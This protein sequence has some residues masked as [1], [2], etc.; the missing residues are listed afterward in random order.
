[1]RVFIVPSWCPTKERPE[2]GSFFLEQAHAIAQIK[3]DWNV[4]ICTFDLNKS[5]IPWRPGSYFPFFRRFANTP[6]LTTTK[7]ASGLHIYNSFVP[8]FPRFGAESKWNGVVQGLKAHIQIA[9]DAYTLRFGK[10]DLIHAHAV[11]PAG[12]AASMIGTKFNIPVALTEHLG[13]F[14]PPQFRRSDGS[15]FSLI[16]KSYMA[17]SS[18][19]A[20]SSALANEITSAGLAS[21]I[22]VIPNFLPEDYGMCDIRHKDDRSNISILSVGGPSVDKGTDTLLKAFANIDANAKLKIIGSSPEMNYF[23]YVSDSLGISERVQWIGAVSREKMRY[24]YKNCDLFVLPSQSETFGVVLIEALAF[25][26]PLISTYCGGPEDIVNKGN[27]L[28]VPV[29]KVDLLSDAMTRL[30]G[31]LENYDCEQLRNDFL[32]RFSAGTVVDRIES[33]YGRTIA[34]HK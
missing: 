34:N 6:R 23:K 32:I 13:P 12:A 4:A 9:L 28:L 15:I 17:A 24:H 8:Y 5:R 7:A 31:Q 27:G 25:G 1:M 26:K 19:S 11:Y 3:S 2:N 14:P 20:V 22:V 29:G 30:I 16:V 21:D 18:H 10:P 33:W